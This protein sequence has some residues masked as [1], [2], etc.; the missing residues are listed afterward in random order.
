MM[1]TV[2]DDS[3]DEPTPSAPHGRLAPDV[4]HHA[5]LD[6]RMVRAA[7]GIRLLALA[8]WP[9]E[10]G[11][12]FLKEFARG[13]VRLPEV[14]YPAQDFT[15]ARRELDA[16]VREADRDHPLG[17]YLA[18]SARSWSIAAELCGSLGTPRVSD[19]SVALFGRPDEPLPGHG[20]TTR[21]AAQ[22]FISIANELDHALLA[23]SEQIRISATALSLQL[24]RDLDDFF[25]GRRIEVQLDPD[26]IAKAAAGATRIRLRTG[27]AFSEYDRQQLLQHEAFVHSLTALNGREQPVL[28]SLA[29]S[30]PRSTAT[31]EGLATFAEQITGS[32]DIGRMKRLSLRIEAVARALDGADFVEV[33]R[34]FLD[35]GQ[36]AEDSFASAQRVFRGVPTTG[37]AAFTKDTVYLRGLVGVHTFFRWSLRQQKLHLGR[38]LFAGKM[39][40]ADVQ[41]FEP[42]FDCGVLKRPRWLPPWIVRANGL[43]GMLA[44]SLFANRIRLDAIAGP[45]A[46]ADL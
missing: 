2:H 37:G 24:Q 43:A 33:F 3:D 28:G 17:Q 5:A 42:L 31:Q 20:P 27:A 13:R 7:R 21:E 4:A 40:L 36:T 19:L 38:W 44:F 34:Y 26:L 23:P 8:S 32:I 12:R 16:I 30:S 6:A 10:V 18:E 25:D 39:T 9:A 15:E 1:E 41:R 35:Q 46:V 14:R 45:D 22:H 11:M 29:L